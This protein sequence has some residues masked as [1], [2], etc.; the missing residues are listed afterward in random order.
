[1][2]VPISEHFRKLGAPLANIRWSWGSVR[3]RDDAVFLR[4]W[5]DQKI[6]LGERRFV[7]LTAYAHFLNKP[8]DPGWNERLQH[9]ERIKGGGQGLSGALLRH[10]RECNAP[11]HQH[12]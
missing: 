8:D 1:M 9:V 4:V 3:A 2:P 5:D 11:V 10:G 7:R 12:L 6:K